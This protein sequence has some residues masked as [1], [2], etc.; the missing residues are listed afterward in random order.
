MIRTVLLDLDNTLL[1]NPIERFIPAYVDRLGNYMRDRHPKERFVEQLLLATKAMMESLDPA[2][3][4]EQ[5]FEAAFYEPLGT[6]P[7][8]LREP[9]ESFYREEYPKL[10]TLARRKAAAFELVQA[11]REAGLELVVATNPLF[12]RVA[13]EQRLAWAG[14]PVED[15]P[16]ALV[17]SS[18]EFHF[19][20]PHLAYYAEILGRLGRSPD[21]A[22][23]I[24]DDP[25]AD[26]EPARLLGMAAYH[27]D[28]DGELG[29]SG[30]PLDG[31]MHWIEHEAPAQVD[32]SAA[33]RPRIL[34][35]HLRGQLG[36]LRST[37]GGL[38]VD[39]WL[40]RPP[41]GSWSPLEITCHLRDVEIEVNLARVQL[42]LAESM[43][44]ISM[45]H[46]DEWAEERNYQSQDPQ[47][48]LQVLTEARQQLIQILLSIEPDGWK[49]QGRHAL[50]GPTS[51]R[52]IVGFGVEHERKHLEQL[53]GVLQGEGESG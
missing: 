28:E 27:V 20:K 4:L 10:R 48:A 9:I 25:E 38:G 52:E 39:Q 1:D 2:H 21:E 37:I 40:R 33:H 16:F 43:P 50:F 23:M 42:I 14:L 45:K 51:L 26:L 53:R 24:G 12:P 17:T 13:I 41:D 15:I 29:A 18:E 47:A 3:T 5:T 19:G 7:E 32:A 30:G 22:A 8:A 11:A 44:F 31:V 46:T 34:M 6:T 49:R 35:A 36:A